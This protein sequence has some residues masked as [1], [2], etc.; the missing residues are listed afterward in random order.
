M[1]RDE[2]DRAELRRLI[3][4]KG[5]KQTWVAEHSEISINYLCLILK[6]TRTPSKRVWKLLAQT[7]DVDWA[8]L[9][10]SKTKAS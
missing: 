10:K 1:E 9:A 6:G 2:F 4:D 7:L 8:N 5:L 3:N